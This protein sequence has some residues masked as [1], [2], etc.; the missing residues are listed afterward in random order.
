M[1]DDPVRP[2]EAGPTVELRRADVVLAADGI[3]SATWNT[4]FPGRSAVTS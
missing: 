2:A 1:P 4:L 3:H